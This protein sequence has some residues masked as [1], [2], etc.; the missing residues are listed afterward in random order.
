MIFPSEWKPTVGDGTNWARSTGLLAVTDIT[1]LVVLG[2][3]LP[4]RC[5]II[6]SL[7]PGIYTNR[8]FWW[9][10]TMRRTACPDI[11][12]NYADVLLL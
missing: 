1:A 10:L 2:M 7:S 9:R 4:A 3:L 6:K 12:T 11:P 8:H 5:V